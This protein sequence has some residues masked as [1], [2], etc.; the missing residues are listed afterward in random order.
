MVICGFTTRRTAASWS[1]ASKLNT[2]EHSIHGDLLFS[3]N[4]DVILVYN[5]KTEVW[6]ILRHMSD[7][8]CV[9]RLVLCIESIG[10][11]DIGTTCDVNHV[12]W[13]M[14]SNHPWGKKGEQWN[15]ANLALYHKYWYFCD[16]HLSWDLTINHINNPYA[17]R[18]L[19]SLSHNE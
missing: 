14:W 17:L 10:L 12:M 13:I 5:P 2:Y 9:L 4:S 6:S 7:S 16:I 18:G 1:V 8:C 11:L 15:H 3:Y 19:C